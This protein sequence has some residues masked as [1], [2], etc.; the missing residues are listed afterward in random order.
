MLE[1]CFLETFWF[2]R[3]KKLHYF[4]G[5]MNEH[6]KGISEGKVLSLLLVENAF[7]Y[8]DHKK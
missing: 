5:P 3:E 4:F 6:D 8:D 1:N 2:K 7:I